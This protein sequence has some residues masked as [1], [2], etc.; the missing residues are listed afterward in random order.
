MSRK[1]TVAAFV[2]GAALLTVA[3]PAAQATPTNVRLTNDNRA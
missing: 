3:I 2:L 1:G